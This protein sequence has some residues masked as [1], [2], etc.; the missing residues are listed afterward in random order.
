MIRRG[1]CCD[2]TPSFDGKELSQNTAIFTSCVN[3]ILGSLVKGSM[4][5]VLRVLSLIV[6]MKRSMS[7]TCSFKAQVFN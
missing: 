6:F 2:D 5:Y 3:T 1:E 7:G 4:L